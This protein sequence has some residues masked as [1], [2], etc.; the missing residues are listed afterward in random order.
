MSGALQNH[1]PPKARGKWQKE[2][3]DHASG[4][5]VVCEWD[6]E[7]LEGPDWK[8]AIEDFESLFLSGDGDTLDLTDDYPENPQVVLACFRS[9]VASLL[10]QYGSV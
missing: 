5:P 10:S 4:A 8:Q 7:G 1:Q 2:I 9:A 6:S 3:V